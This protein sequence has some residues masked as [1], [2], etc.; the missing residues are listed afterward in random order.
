MAAFYLHNGH[1]KNRH[2]AT[3]LPSQGRAHRDRRMPDTL[4]PASLACVVSTSPVPD[5]VAKKEERTYGG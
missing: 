5:A 4:W 1:F 3:H 2:A